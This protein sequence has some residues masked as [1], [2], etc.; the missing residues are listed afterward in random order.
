MSKRGLTPH[1]PLDIEEAGLGKDGPNAYRL[2]PYPYGLSG[3]NAPFC[4]SDIFISLGFIW[5]LSLRENPSQP[6]CHN[7]VPGASSRK[8]TVRH[9]WRYNK[10]LEQ[11]KTRV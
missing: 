10:H 6:F 7:G 2:Q 3:R 11:S 8:C 1:I 4:Q 9:K 5:L